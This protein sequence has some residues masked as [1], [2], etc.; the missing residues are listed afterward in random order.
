MKLKPLQNHFDLLFVCKEEE[1]R[2]NYCDFQ[3]PL[4]HSGR[5][6]HPRSKVRNYVKKVNIFSFF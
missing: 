3:R 2:K 4:G 6:P 5:L 1:G